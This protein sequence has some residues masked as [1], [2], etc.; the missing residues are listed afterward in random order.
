[1]DRLFQRL[2]LPLLLL[3]VLGVAVAQTPAFAGASTFTSDAFN[4]RNLIR[5]LWSFTD[6]NGD[7]TLR[8]VGY[9]TDSA[10]VQIMIPGGGEH[11]L[12]QFGYNVPRFTQA[13]ANENFVVEAKF[14][15]G[16][17]GVSFQSY[18]AQGIVVEQDSANLIRF[19]FTTGHE[20]DS[21]K[22]FAAAFING[23]SSPSVKINDRFFT[24]YNQ[25]PMWLRV[26]RTGNTWKMYY[27]M[28][29]STFTLADSFVQALNVT[30]IG[31]FAGNA[32]PNPAPFTSKIDYFFNGDSPIVPEEGTP[33]NDNLGPLIYNVSH[34]VQPNAMVVRWKTDEPANGTVEWGATTSYEN[35]PV[36]HAGYSH[37]HRLIVSGLNSSTDYHLRVKGTDDSLNTN[38]SGDYAFNS[39]PYIDDRQLVSDDFGAAPLNTSLW[40]TVNPRNDATFGIA[41]KK[42]TIAV[43]GGVAHDIWTDGYKAPRIMQP[44][45][46]FANVYEFAVK[47]TTPLVGSASNIMVQGIVVEQDTN[48][49]I[50]AN[51]SYD[52]SNVRLFIAAFSDGLSAPDVIANEVLSGATSNLWLRMTQGGGTFRVYYSLNGTTWSFIPSFPRPMNVTKI[53]VFAGNGG[54]SPQAFTCSAEYVATSLPAKPYLGTPLNNAVSVG[55]PVT[56]VWDTTASAASYRLQVSTDPGFGTMVYNDSTITVPTKQVPGLGYTTQ[57]Y[58]RVRG[59]SAW[60]VGAYSD[61]YNFTTAVA[62]PAAPVAVSPAANAVDV[63]V[64]PT[65]VW[66]KP[67]GTVT[68]RLQVGTDSTFASGLVFNDSTLTDSTRALSGLANLTKYYW[69]VNAKNAGGTSGYSAMRAFTTISAIPA[70]PALVT[71]I[72]NAVNQQAN[73]TLRW[74]RSNGAL[75]YRLQVGTDETFATGVVFDDSTLTD[76]TRAMTGLTNSTKY[77]WRVNAKNTAGTGVFSAP[78]AFT[79]IVANPS[80]PVLVG[81]LDGAV[82]Q[83]LTVQYV[84]RKTTGATSYRLQVASDSTFATGIVVNDSTI[85]DSTK[86]VGGLSFGM[87]YFWRVNSK[88]IGGT[89]P[90]SSVWSFRTYDADPS[91]PRQLSPTDQSTGLLPPVTLVWTRPAGATSFHLQVS[92]DSTFA[93]GFVVND[94]AATDTIRTVNGLAYLTTYYWRVNAD[95]VSGTSPWSPKR[96]FS[97]AIPMASAPALLFPLNLHRQ[98]TDS[99]MVTWR[100]SQP[101]VD[102]YQ[103]DLAVDSLF[104][105]VV[106]D[107]NVTDTTKMFKS[108]LPNQAYFW[109]VRAHNAG[110]WGPFSEVRRFT[111]DITSVNAR[112]EVPTSFELAQNYPNP[113]NPATQ[114]EFALP[115][116]SR[117][118]IEV[119]N[120][121]GA[122]VA[123]LVDEVRGAGYHSVRFDASSLP[124][125]LYLYR[126]AAD[127]TSFIRKMMLVK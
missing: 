17:Q 83:N 43:P 99:I 21:V 95:A 54:A 89:S 94:A 34:V 102:R 41:G 18:Q 7:A 66:T 86:S 123:T 15:S 73:L 3:L 78:W 77:Y 67:A 113:F 68:F 48:N 58:W 120:L 69:R 27:S 84:W 16:M 56:M 13:C 117:V 118:T 46:D 92:T 97:T 36:S 88:N 114:I 112:P 51:F 10:Q 96:R 91:V 65:L 30:R 108:L 104:V 72:N 42:L 85:T 60:G 82:D 4:S 29:G 5:P 24:G 1:M 38:A 127:Q 64:A 47:F 2:R 25:A 63:A 14:L 39:G 76:T 116:E 70:A 79:T 19:D 50:R 37:D 110:G 103:V 12:W 31:V 75:T 122:R 101:A 74:N 93:G 9:K 106:S 23:F 105:F 32:G 115:K 119:F 107:Q 87:K 8:M 59:K 62:P 22:A 44:V 125:G 6:P 33:V 35:T 90:Y 45:K 40:S 98:M 126:M 80:I 28:N 100:K 109:R 111:R 20:V 71:P 26:T 124:S 61:V 55:T 11:D 57:Y 52:G 53:G 121:L 81:P 49:I